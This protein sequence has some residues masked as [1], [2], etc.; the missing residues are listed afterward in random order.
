MQKFNLARLLFEMDK[1]SSESS[2]DSVI[3]ISSDEESLS[4]DWESDYS[5]GTEEKVARIE[6]EVTSG[7]MLLGG[8]NMTTGSLEEEMVAGPSSAVPKQSVTLKFDGV[9]VDEKL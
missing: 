6:H 8:R 3:Y 9:Y 1:E 5:T 7:P 4:E 2:N